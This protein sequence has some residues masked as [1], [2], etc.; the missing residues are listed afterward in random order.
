M[1]TI[2]PETLEIDPQ[3]LSVTG[4]YA[5]GSRHNVHVVAN[6]DL[7]VI[8]AAGQDRPS[9]DRIPCNVEDTGLV[10]VSLGIDGND[11]DE[12]HYSHRPRNSS[13]RR[14][15]RRRSTHSRWPGMR[16]GGPPKVERGTKNEPPTV[17]GPWAVLWNHSPKRF[18]T[19][20]R[21]L[22]PGMTRTPNRSS[23]LPWKCPKYC[24]LSTARVLL[25]EPGFPA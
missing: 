2:A 7:E 8:L 11:H 17:S 19:C 21:Q 24:N 3:H 15:S 12:V 14:R 22:C 10:V 18:C 20:R 1:T 4:V 23:H 6:S 16:R 13:P 25:N 5:S 9:H